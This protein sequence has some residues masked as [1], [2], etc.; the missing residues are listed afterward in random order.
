M[1]FFFE[2]TIS[3]LILILRAVVK[4]IAQIMTSDIIN[5]II[6]VA[7]NIYPPHLMYLKQFTEN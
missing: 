4:A 3:P 5:N 6:P 2:M 1:R 7:R